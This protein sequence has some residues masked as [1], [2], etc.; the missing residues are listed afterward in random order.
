MV[1]HGL[2]L[3]V[4]GVG[5]R[6]FLFVKGVGA[7]RF[8]V[9]LFISTETVGRS[10]RLFWRKERFGGFDRGVTDAIGRLGKP[11][12]AGLRDQGLSAQKRSRQIYSDFRIDQNTERFRRTNIG[13][14]P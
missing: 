13:D 4:K 8:L 1:F 14:R 10:S 11:K 12:P 3:F 2:F 6:L 7:L 9:C 5:A